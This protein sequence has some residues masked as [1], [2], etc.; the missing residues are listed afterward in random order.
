MST[1]GITSAWLSLCRNMSH[2]SQSATIRMD[3]LSIDKISVPEVV[4]KFSELG[5][6]IH[7]VHERQSN[8]L[9]YF[10]QLLGIL[11]H[12]KYDIVHVNGSSSL[13]TLEMIAAKLSNIPIR[14]SH[15]H[16]TA[17]SHILLH[18]LLWRLLNFFSNLR[19][20]CGK[21]AGKWLFGSNPYKIFHNGID[22]NLFLF[23]S[24][25][26]AL[27][28]KKMHIDEDTLL[29]GH[30]G[31][32][33]YQKNHEFLVDVFAEIIKH[34]LNSKLVLFVDGNLMEEIKEKVKNIHLTSSI[35]F[36]GTVDNI[37]DYLNALD[38]ML[39]PSRFEG[40]PNVV[41][42]WQAS[43]LPSIV[44][45][46]VTKECS[47]TRLVRFLSLNDSS[48]TWAKETISMFTNCNDRLIQSA[49]A[50]DDLRKNNFD[51]QGQTIKLIALY[52]NSLA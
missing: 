45:D 50:I 19:I 11:K 27:I 21:D 28:R 43:G 16:N 12:E 39:L 4:D 34:N 33:N 29:I 13:M 22:L 51:I 18:H 36:M 6:R 8:I 23:N 31:K 10:R 14:L 37:A 49:E 52:Q 42:E 20:A 38:V 44:A 7:H 40:L 41:I 26:R 15:S 25:K 24:N 48:K 17:C 3:F 30:V 35:L 2:S 32:F 46:T 47:Q 1:D 9:R 5:F